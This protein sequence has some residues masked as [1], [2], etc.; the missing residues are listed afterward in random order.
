MQVKC[1]AAK[2]GFFNSHDDFDSIPLSKIR[3]SQRGRRPQLP[4]DDHGLMQTSTQVQTGIMLKQLESSLELQSGY[5]HNASMEAKL[6]SLKS[7]CA[8]EPIQPLKKKVKMTPGGM[9]FYPW[10]HSHTENLLLDLR[11]HDIGIPLCFQRPP[12]LFPDDD[13]DAAIAK[14]CDGTFDKLDNALMQLD[15]VA[16]PF[17]DAMQN[18]TSVGNRALMEEAKAC[19]E[20]RLLHFKWTKGSTGIAKPLITC[21]D[22]SSAD[23]KERARSIFAIL[24]PD[25]KEHVSLEQLTNILRTR[26]NADALSRANYVA[27][28]ARWNKS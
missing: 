6:D 25:V 1:N 13:D 7:L 19:P 8:E 14:V 28:R 27:A 12:R 15:P 5:V 10:L 23:L 26:S 9:P 17:L 3:K 21:D 24:A 18:Q 16:R 2:H 4:D 11:W 20:N 22:Q